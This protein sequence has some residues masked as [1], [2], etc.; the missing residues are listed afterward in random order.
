E[1]QRRLVRTYFRG[2][3][4]ALLGEPADR[5]WETPDEFFAALSNPDDAFNHEWPL[6]GREDIIANLS[7][8]LADPAFRIVL[9]SGGG[10]S[11]KSRILKQVLGQCGDVLPGWTPLLLTR[12]GEIS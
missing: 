1:A 12:D 6:V 7:A 4:L 3:E 2:Q 11:G 8:A 5:T 10:G 9:L